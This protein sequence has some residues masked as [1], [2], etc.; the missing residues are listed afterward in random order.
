MQGRYPASL[1]NV[2]D[3]TKEPVLLVPE[4]IHE[5]THDIFFHQ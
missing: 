4:T 3:S 2:G 1:W 5:E